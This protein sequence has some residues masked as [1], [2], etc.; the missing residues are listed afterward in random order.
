MKKVIFVMVLLLV[1]VLL[2]AQYN[3][4]GRRIFPGTITNT[5]IENNSVDGSEMLEGTRYLWFPCT[6]DSMANDGFVG[7]GAWTTDGSNGAGGEIVGTA[8][9]GQIRTFIFDGDTTSG[10]DDYAYLTF[11]VPDDYETDSMELYLYWFH[12][13]QDGAATDS[14]YWDGTVQAVASAEDLFGAGTGMTA[15]LTVCAQGD[16]ALYITNLDPEVEALVSGDL[17]TIQVFVDGTVSF[18]AGV[19]LEDG[20]DSNEDVHLIGALIEYEIKDE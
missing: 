18:G 6:L 5:Q 13:D 10:D 1:P 15:V 9:T 8:G 20:L 17:V 16:S 4:D 14:V 7:S 2:S 19:F 3:Q 11:V 12:L